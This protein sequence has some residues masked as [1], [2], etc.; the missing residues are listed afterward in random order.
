MSKIGGSNRVREELSAAFAEGR[1]VTAKVKWVT[2]TDEEGRN[3]WIHC[4]PL[5]GV[6]GQIGVWMVVIVNEE[7]PNNYFAGG[8]R[9]APPIPDR[10]KTLIRTKG[11]VSNYSTGF[12]NGSTG[13][14]D[15]DH[16]SYSGDSVTSLR[17]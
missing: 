5:I 9:I 4:T 7:M 8:A 1:G 15:E 2:K 14:Q 10:S 17:L 11:H 6:N 3:K 16:K 13:G 12:S